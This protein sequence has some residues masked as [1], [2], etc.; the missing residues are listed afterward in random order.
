MFF[1]ESRGSISVQISEDEIP[2]V[3]SDDEYSQDFE[4]SSPIELEEEI[5]EADKEVQNILKR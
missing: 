4:P 5:E 2:E 1:K 3:Y